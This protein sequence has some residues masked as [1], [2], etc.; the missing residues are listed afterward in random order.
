MDT[1]RFSLRHL[2]TA[3]LV[4]FLICGF[5]VTPIAAAE[6]Q[7]YDQTMFFGCVDADS[8]TPISNVNIIVAM[9]VIDTDNNFAY[10]HYKAVTDWMGRALIR[11]ENPYKVTKLVYGAIH[12]DYYAA[13]GDIN[14]HIEADCIVVPIPMYAKDGDA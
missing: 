3:A 10:Y 1:T 14:S 8:N 5:T 4:M 6:T 7:G 12:P 13:T 9:T 11:I 2:L